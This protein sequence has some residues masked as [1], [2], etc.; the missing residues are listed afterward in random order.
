MTPSNSESPDQLNGPRPLVSFFIVSY[1][2]EEYT[3]A[4]VESAF[5]QTYSP[6]EI[7]LSDDGSPDGTFEVMKE[8]AATY[9]GP[10]KV[11]INQ[12]SPNRRLVGHVNELMA[13]S[14]GEFVVKNDGDDISTSDR[15]EKLVTRWLESDKKAK[16]V[17]SATVSIDE[18][19]QVIGRHEPGKAI[20][21]IMRK[22]PTP[23]RIVQ[24]D[25][26]ARGATLSW[27]RELYDKFGPMSEAAIADDSILPFRAAVLGDIAYVDEPLVYHRVGGVSWLDKTKNP[28]HEK[29]YGRRIKLFE[30]H[31]ESKRAMLQDLGK[32]DI[33]E[34]RAIVDSIS[35]YIKEQNYRIE[36]SQ[37]SI[38]ELITKMPKSIIYSII[39]LRLHY[40][41]LNIK[42]ILHRL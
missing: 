8:M 5:S 14:S 36:L 16:L 2:Q 27:S 4:A 10:H 11:M 3:R 25:L 18:K 41:Y 15:V 19:G 34:K 23:L 20:P 30:S 40:V 39:N 6:L 42:Y 33:S 28:R 31:I 17:F 12:N 26:H 22:K 1:K 9:R 32:S 38:I 35:E 13:I 24:K 29:M 37:K 7:I 21:D